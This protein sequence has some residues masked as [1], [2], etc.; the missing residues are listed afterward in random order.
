MQNFLIFFFVLP[1]LGLTQTEMSQENVSPVVGKI[2]CL[3]AGH[4]GTAKTD[5]F[6][7][8]PKGEREEWINLRVALLLQKLLEKKGAKVVMTRTT[9]DT[10]SLTRR[11]KIAKENNSDLF[12]VYTP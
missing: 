10:I 2:I 8:G 7:A 11:A 1:C 6:R 4:A 3:D 12:F 5:S 9:D